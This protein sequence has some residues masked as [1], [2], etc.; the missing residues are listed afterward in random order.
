[1]TKIIETFKSNASPEAAWALL[2]DFGNIDFFN[3]NLKDSYLLEGSSETG[4]GTLR[5]CNLADGKNYIRERVVDWKEGESYTI[6]IYEG[7]MPLTNILTTLGVRPKGQGSELFMEMEYT[8]KYGPV[9]AIMN[10]V[11]L[12]RYV[13]G[14]MA[15]VLSGLDEKA[16]MRP[17]L[18]A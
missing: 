14:M 16:R 15:K 6:D 10:V 8:P 17:V 13:R 4:V 18:A 1:M 7:T 12:R 2:S 3:P 11:M 9:G 5:Q